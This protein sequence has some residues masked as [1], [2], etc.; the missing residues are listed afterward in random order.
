ML[1]I[2]DEVVAH[3]ISRLRRLGEEMQPVALAKCFTAERVARE[4]AQDHQRRHPLPVRW[5]FIDL[6]AAIGGA[7][8]LD[9]VRALSGE[10]FL[11]M[12]AAQGFEPS[13]DFAHDRAIVKGLAAFAADPAQG[14]RERRVRH[15]VTGRGRPAAGQEQS[16]S[17]RVAQFCLIAPPVGGHP[18][19]HHVAFLGRPRRRL[20]QFGEG[21]R[22]V[23]AVEGD[24]GIDRAGNGHGVRRLDADFADAALDIPVDR[25]FRRRPTRAIERERQCA[26]ARIQDKA[27]AA[28]ARALRLGDAL[29]RD[30]RDRCVRRVAAPPQH[31]ERGQRGHRV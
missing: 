30:R 4:R 11:L 27:I 31:I 3:P 13:D 14:G 25:S 20:E 12:K 9:P 18:R 15:S 16:G 22:A 7:D 10:I 21:P 24:P 1:G 29:H 6:V 5:A 23:L 8:R 26:F 2:A 19:C 17:H 28:D